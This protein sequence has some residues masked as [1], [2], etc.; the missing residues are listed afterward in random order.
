MKNAKNWLLAGVFLLVAVTAHASQDVDLKPVLKNGNEKFK[1]ALVRSG[2]Y[3]QYAA[4]FRHM[5]NG[6]KKHGWVKDFSLSD[7]AG[8]TVPG[9]MQA[10]AGQDFSD[11][12]VF[13]PEL[14]FDFQFDDAKANEPVFKRLIEKGSGADLIV[15]FGTRASK[16]IA[17]S[18]ALAVPVIAVQISDPI[19]AG[20]VRSCDDSGNPLITARCDL[21]KYSRQIK[22]F[23]DVVNF[24]RLG[25]IYENTPTGRAIAAMDHVEAL[26]KQRGFR[27]VED[28]EAVANGPQAADQYLEAVKRI[29]PKI[30]ALYLTIHGGLTLERLPAIMEAVNKYKVPTFAMEG[31]QFVRHGVLLSISSQEQRATGEYNAE[32]IVRI[33]K[34][35]K[36]GGLDQKFAITPMIAINLK[37]AMLIGY[38][39]PVDILA[40]SDE[41]YE[42]IELPKKK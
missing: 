24:S 5:L 8:E 2:E 40:A 27:I 28:T 6:L 12:I 10:L 32:K 39:P 17:N 1:I 35:E 26:A 20:V 4:N 42:E 7:K 33:L 31:P 22:V 23:H 13:S 19:K 29:A 21:E 41:V 25:M 11:Y 38:D 34:G 3:W 37:E 14:Y 15:S 18:A 30:D 16:A 36:P 9:I